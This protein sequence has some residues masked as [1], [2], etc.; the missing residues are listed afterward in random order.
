MNIVFIALVRV[1]LL[2]NDDKSKGL[3]FKHSQ[4]PPKS[5]RLSPGLRANAAL[6]FLGCLKPMNVLILV[7]MFLSVR[8]IND[9]KLKACFS[10]HSQW[11]PKAFAFRRA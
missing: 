10:K 2:V 11:P 6:S 5:F 7:F 1:F 8:K 4:W 9:D 3:F